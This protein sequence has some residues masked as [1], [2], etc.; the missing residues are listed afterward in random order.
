MLHAG[1]ARASTERN[2]LILHEGP[3]GYERSSDL[4]ATRERAQDPFD[5]DHHHDGRRAFDLEIRI[6]VEIAQ[7]Q[8]WYP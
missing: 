4:L 5:G 8:E 7:Q 3:L 1:D 2:A 6:R